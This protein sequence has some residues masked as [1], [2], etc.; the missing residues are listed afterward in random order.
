MMFQLLFT[1]KSVSAL[2]DSHPENCFIFSV[3]IISELG[4]RIAL[5]KL[6]NSKDTDNI[7][8]KLGL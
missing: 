4:I 2:Q 6:G 8:N 1:W 3:F 7:I 5:G